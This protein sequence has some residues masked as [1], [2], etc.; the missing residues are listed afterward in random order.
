MNLSQNR[1]PRDLTDQERTI[2]EWMIDHGTGE[3]ELY[4]SQLA[5]ATVVSACD[6]GCPS[7]DFAIGGK[8]PEDRTE[9]EL[10]GDYFY[11]HENELCGVFVFAC[12][13]QLA[14]IEFY[15]LA[16][17]EVPP[18]IPSPDS[19]R[20]AVFNIDNTEREAGR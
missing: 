18:E 12:N 3:K 8:E 16:A 1:F 7:I 13:G 20:P 11:G 14:G 10:L 15:T 4:R 2:T 9:R 19:L 17:E 5:Q 6:C